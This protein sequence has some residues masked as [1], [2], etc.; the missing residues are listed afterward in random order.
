MNRLGDL[1]TASKTHR[2]HFAAITVAAVPA[3]AAIVA[4]APATAVAHE[5]HRTS[6]LTEGFLH[7]LLGV[8]HLVTMV[9]VGLVSVVVG[10]GAIWRVPGMF[11]LMLAVGGIVG[12]R[13]WELVGVELWI[14]GSLTLFGV[15]LV[16]GPA[17]R[18]S[19]TLAAVALFGFA[20]GNAHGL[21]LPVTVTPVGYTAGFVAASAACHV[22]GIGI[23]S[24]IMKS[25]RRGG[26]LVTSGWAILTAALLIAVGAT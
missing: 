17:L 20:H 23:G 10:G 18:L 1:L 12:F 16:T 22:T 9:A 3:A 8:D 15:T 2:A 26:L 25:R 21:E 13:G 6:G 7:P 11:V 19:W 14:L 4:L 24:L 5:G